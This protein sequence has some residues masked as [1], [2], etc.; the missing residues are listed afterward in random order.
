M[1]ALEPSKQGKGV[2]PGSDRPKN[3]HYTNRSFSLVP[4]WCDT[5]QQSP[6]GIGKGPQTVLLLLLDSTA[7]TADNANEFVSGAASREERGTELT[8]VITVKLIFF[9][10]S[11][12]R[13]LS[14]AGHLVALRSIASTSDRRAIRRKLKLGSFRR[15]CGCNSHQS[16]PLAG[17]GVLSSRPD[18]MPIQGVF[19]PAERR[20]HN[21]SS[22]RLDPERLFKKP[23]NRLL[24]LRV[25]G[26]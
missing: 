10:L 21:R 15:A 13:T 18:T 7:P 20:G 1:G 8:A 9:S 14:N 16:S 25:R 24:R 12:E 22:I 11:L 6:Y 23:E 2:R 3:G 5:A 26:R 19:W 4:E 17:L